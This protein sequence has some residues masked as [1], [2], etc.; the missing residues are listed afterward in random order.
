MRE[1]ISKRLLAVAMVL[2][3]L[4][5]QI[6]IMTTIS[7][8][9]PSNDAFQRTWARHDDPVTAGRAERTWMWGP[10]AYTP[11]LTEEYLESPGAERQVQYF[12]KS[13]MEINNPRADSSAVWYVTNGL[14]VTE[15]ITGRMQIG[16]NTFAQREPAELNVAGDWDDAFGPTY[17]TFA[18]TDVSTGYGDGV[19]NVRL[20]RD[21]AVFFDSTLTERGID[22]PHR[23][24]VTGHYVARPFWE[25]MN[26]SGIVLDNDDYEINRLFEDPLFATGR[27]ITRAYWA[28]VKVDGLYQDVLL[29][30]FER[31]CLT[32]TPGNPDG[33]QVEAGNVGQHYHGWRYEQPPIATFWEPHA[34]AVGD[35]GTVY[36]GSGRN[37]RILRFSVEGDFLGE[38]G[39]DGDGLGKL[40]FPTGI[41]VDSQG[42]V[43]VVEHDNHRVQKFTASGLAFSVWGGNGAGEGK[44]NH[45]YGIAIDADDNVYVTDHFNHRVQKFT[46]DGTFLAAWG[47]FGPSDPAHFRYPSGVAIDED[48]VVYVADTLNDRVQ[49]FTSDGEYMGEFGGGHQNSDTDLSLPYGVAIDAQERVYV[50]DSSN[51]RVQIYDSGGAQSGSWDLSWVG[52]FSRP[53]GLA[54]DAQGNVYVTDAGEYQV[55]QFNSAGEFQTGLA[56]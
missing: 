4:G 31:R 48:G 54:I 7:A 26:S 52:Q 6:A 56:P 44:F 24:P 30:C 17:A 51:R 35:D 34:V 53:A 27:P 22:N 45:P 37:N 39:S 20:N 18:A 8:D 11:E 40:A 29:Q 33:W 49:T 41:A 13:R 50:A 55:L 43:Y 10:Q 2:A 46:S 28:N 16:D 3:L 1:R 9:A 38:W 23:D 32:Y 12:D 15:L 42:D 25:F 21:G 19:I 36:V 5:A 14:L 47:T